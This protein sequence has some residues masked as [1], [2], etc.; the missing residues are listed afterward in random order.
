MPP[1]SAPARPRPPAPPFR[2]RPPQGGI[3]GKSPMPGQKPNFRN[4]GGKTIPFMADGGL[5]A[6]APIGGGPAAA[7]PA[8][9]DMDN[10]QDQDAGAGP[11]VKPEAVGY[12]DHLV[13]CDSCTNYGQDGN[14]ALLRMQVSG[15]GGCQAWDAAGGEGEEAGGPMQPGEDMGEGADMG[16]GGPQ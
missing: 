4:V 11:V 7:A 14:C 16:A 2:P 9:P 3:P 15:E 6:P 8:P 1:F 13:R 12:H 5:G 10:D